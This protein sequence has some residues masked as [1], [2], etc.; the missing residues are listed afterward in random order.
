MSLQ[1]CSIICE[2]TYPTP[3]GLNVWY[4]NTFKALFSILSE[5]LEAEDSRSE[6][7]RTCCIGKS[8]I[9]W[10]SSSSARNGKCK[11]F[12][13]L[14]KLKT[15]VNSI[16][17]MREKF[18][19]DFRFSSTWGFLQLSRVVSEMKGRRKNVRIRF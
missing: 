13:Q 8:I 17:H 6:H 11:K 10:I 2:Y 3:N 18:V 19:I 15:I 7:W 9:L 14:A 4:S 16:W 12:I 5:A 1:F